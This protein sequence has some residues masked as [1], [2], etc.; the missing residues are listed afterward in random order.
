[1]AEKTKA[2]KSGG[3]VF[4]FFI[5]TIFGGLIGLGLGW[6]AWSQ[7]SLLGGDVE[8]FRKSFMEKYVTNATDT[9][10]RETAE[11]AESLASKLRNDRAS[12]PAGDV[13]MPKEQP[14]P[15]GN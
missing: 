6:V 3:G 1:M 14:L 9:A 4:P 12:G 5:G 10:K 7:S 15:R 13:P 2:K 11:W 8:A